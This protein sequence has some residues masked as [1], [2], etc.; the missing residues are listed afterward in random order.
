MSRFGEAHVKG[1]IVYL[2]AFDVAN[3]I[4]TANVSKILSMKPFP[5]AI[6]DSRTSPRYPAIY[7]PLAVEQPPL[8]SQL[9]GR[10]VRPMI[11]VFEVGV[12]TIT[13]RVAFETNS[14]LDLL[15]FH[16]PKLENGQSLGEAAKH[17]CT[18]VCESLKE[19]M[20]RGS[21]PMEAEQYTAF[22][23]T[24]I[25]GTTDV[26]SW[27]DQERNAVAALLAETEPG[28]LSGAQVGEVLRLQ[29][30]F[31]KS[32]LVV[33]DWDAAL[34][35]DL[36]GYVDDVL[37]VLELANLQLEEFRTMDRILDRYLDRAYEHLERRPFSLFGVSSAVL[38]TLRWFRVDLTK[39][40]DEVTHITKFF[41]DWYL[42]RVYLAARE[43]FYLDA[44]RSSV[45]HRLA[46]LDRLYT[47]VHTEINE[48]RMLWLEI[49][50][51][52]FFAIDLLAI[53]VWRR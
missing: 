23:L 50:V 38:R 36:S 42:A 24:E 40:A 7:Q 31:E 51:V 2:F 52:V 17:L 28:R 35:V 3:E 13:L 11:R 15:Q 21:A 20:V 34:V 1:E 10:P 16:S 33:V 45:E 26:G 18:E 30:S 47:V 27:L 19:V 22:C 5:Y 8:A 6:R 12:V 14:L 46:Q 48:R 53:M 41:G 29:R 39:L 32:D 43:R 49:I 37:F 9:A 25:D 44:W 4:L